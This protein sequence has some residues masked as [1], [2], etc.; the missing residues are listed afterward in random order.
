VRRVTL[1]LTAILLL[2]ATTR[3]QAAPEYTRTKNVF[4]GR[5]AGIAPTIDV[6]GRR[7]VHGKGN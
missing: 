5:N 6:L 2:P 1:A 4:H 7:K 3:A